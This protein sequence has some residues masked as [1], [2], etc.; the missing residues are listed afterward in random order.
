[1]ELLLSVEPN[2]QAIQ[3]VDQKI[4]TF[5]DMYGIPIKRELCFVVHE[6]VINAVEAMQ[7]VQFTNV[8]KIEIHVTKDEDLVQ[9]TVTDESGGIPKDKCER[10]LAT[11]FEDVDFSDRGRGFLFIKNM[12]DE[13]WFEHLSDNRFLVGIK[14]K[15]NV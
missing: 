13:V 2:Q 10:I 8:K 12:V 11:N 3:F 14:K 1:M 7:Q 15:I 6:L 9:V 5:A 4:T